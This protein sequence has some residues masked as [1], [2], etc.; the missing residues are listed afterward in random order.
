MNDRGNIARLKEKQNRDTR[1]S[2]TSINVRDKE[3]KSHV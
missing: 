1:A 3:E 2:E